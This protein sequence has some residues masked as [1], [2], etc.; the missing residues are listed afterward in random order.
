M[1]GTPRDWLKF[2]NHDFSIDSRKEFR[3]NHKGLL[4]KEIEGHE[5]LDYAEFSTLKEGAL[6]A[7]EQFCHA[8]AN[9]A[10]QV[11]E[12][13]PKPQMPLN[14]EHE[15]LAPI[16]CSITE[17]VYLVE[18][19]HHL[20]SIFIPKYDSYR[21]IDDNIVMLVL[22]TRGIPLRFSEVQLS[23]VALNPKLEVFYALSYNQLYRSSKSLGYRRVSINVESLS[24]EPPVRDVIHCSNIVFALLID[25]KLIRLDPV[26]HPVVGFAYVVPWYGVV[27]TVSQELVAFFHLVLKVYHIR[28]K[29]LNDFKSRAFQVLR[30]DVQWR[31]PY[32]RGL[33]QQSLWMDCL[34]WWMEVEVVVVVVSLGIRKLRELPKVQLVP[35]V[36]EE[37]VADGRVVF[38]S[39]VGFDFP[40]ALVKDLFNISLR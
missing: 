25:P 22:E 8:S 11:A 27:H 5:A 9:K 3:N 36:E 7:L 20:N 1:A 14:G 32:L 39:F 35:L 12:D 26:D 4:S 23:L 18:A 37:E 6:Q 21:R 34:D 10:F 19:H 38:M 31:Q 16:H 28:M 29:D 2:N 17:F 24:L 40:H 30:L 33:V 15:R 13:P